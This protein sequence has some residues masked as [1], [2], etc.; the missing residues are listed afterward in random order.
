[1][2]DSGVAAV[3]VGKASLPPVVPILHTEVSISGLQTPMLQGPRNANQPLQEMKMKEAA[4]QFESYFTYMM[5]KEMRKGIPK[6]GI[7]SSGVG[8]DIYQSMYDEAIAEEMSKT[9]GL[10]LSKALMDQY[11]RTSGGS[12]SSPLF[13]FSEAI[14]EKGAEPVFQNVG[15]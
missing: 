10:G 4:R 1:M 13:K 2:A 3:G 7:L 9:G 15:R 6:D 8:Y 11:I 12:D 14:S 5:L